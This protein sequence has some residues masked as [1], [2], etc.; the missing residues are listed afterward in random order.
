MFLVVQ[1]H[2]G[3]LYEGVVA[4]VSG[5]VEVSVDF[6]AVARRQ[7]AVDVAVVELEPFEDFDV[8]VEIFAVHE[9]V[10]VAVR[11]VQTSLLVAVVVDAAE[12]RTQDVGAF[13]RFGVDVEALEIVVAYLEINNREVNNILILHPLH[14]SCN[15]KDN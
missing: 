10:V 5:A 12:V 14:Y 8:V 1:R 15:L 7:S 3:V 2:R 6:V 9:K 4:V 13:A 11:D